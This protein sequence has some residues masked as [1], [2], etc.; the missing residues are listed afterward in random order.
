MDRRRK[1][2][3][4]EQIRREY[5]HGAGTIQ[6]VSQKLR[7]HRRMVRQALASAIPPEREAPVRKRPQFGPVTVRKI[8]IAVMLISKY[9][10]NIGVFR[11]HR[12]LLSRL[13][14]ATS[15]I[16]IDTRHRPRIHTLANLHSLWT[17]IR[18][19]PVSFS[20]RWSSL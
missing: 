12:L 2:E 16:T 19:V 14:A 18:I 17:C 7:V 10:T 4:F 13:F 11:Q 6:G 1:A 5:T 15:F 20:F 9:V 8:R 3:L